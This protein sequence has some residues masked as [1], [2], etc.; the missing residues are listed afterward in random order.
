MPGTSFDRVAAIY[1]E[2]RGGQRRGDRFADAI[3]PWVV[4]ERVIEL[5]VGTGVIAH[6]L[7]RHGVDLT[8]FDLSAAM[9]RGALGRLGPR[10]AVADVEQLPLA[11]DSVDTAIFAWVLHLVADIGATLREAARVVRP[12]GRVVAIVADGEDHPDDEMATIFAGLEPLGSANR[13]SEAALDAAPAEL[14]LEYRGFT[15]WETFPAV[16]NEQAD[17]VEQRGYSM[18]FDVDDATWERVVVP[19]I[20]RLRSMPD[21]D[22]PYD[23]RNRHPIIVWTVT[24]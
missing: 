21:P 4:G 15:A 8:G 19:V 14:A 17:L 18:L 6:G 1:D 13:R 10:V 7:R 2:T 11:D 16:P 22:Q 24:P 20:E 3:A 12:G 5:G 23:R 9:L